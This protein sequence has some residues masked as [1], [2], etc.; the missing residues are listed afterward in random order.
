ML[1]F[2][3]RCV[4]WTGDGKVFFYNPSSRISVWE[5]PDALIGR[6]DVD[7]LLAGPPDATGTANSGKAE[8][9]KA[10][11]SSDSS[12]ED[13]RPPSKKAKLDDSKGLKTEIVHLKLWKFIKACILKIF[14]Y[15]VVNSVKEEDAEKDPKKTID[16]GKEAAVEAEVRAARERAIVPL[17]TRI[18]SFKEMLTEKDVLL[19][20]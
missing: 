5:R 9:R 3:F 6:G 17:D 16:I 13:D 4:V 18:K 10:D 2:I 11:D 8:T 7:K 20:F 19:F 14:F 1:I 12:G 15:F